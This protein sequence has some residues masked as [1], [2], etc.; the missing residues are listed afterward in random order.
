MDTHHRATDQMRTHS[1]EHFGDDITQSGGTHS[2][3][4]GS[5]GVE[6]PL[7]ELDELL[8]NAVEQARSIC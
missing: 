8:N 5:T 2:G 6:S 4:A 7:H 1:A 3:T